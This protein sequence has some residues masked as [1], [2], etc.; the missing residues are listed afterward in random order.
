VSGPQLGGPGERLCPSCARFGPQSDP[1]CRHCGYNFDT[2]AGPSWRGAP[3]LAD[4]PETR[5][6]PGTPQPA[7][8]RRWVGRAVT[9]VILIAV[10]STFVGPIFSLFESAKELIKDVPGQIDVDVPEITIPG[11]NGDNGPFGGDAGSAAKC[12]SGIVRYMQKL[13]AKDGTGSRPLNE[14]FIEA[15]VKLGAG[16]FEYRTLVSV[17]SSNQGKALAEGT[18]AGLRGAKRDTN[19]ACNKHYED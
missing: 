4:Q 2:G 12:K 6:A 15:S 9:A 3:I 17:F 10:V 8:R 19:R 14:L 11:I 16:S 1:V 5:T 7:A 13:L 18:R